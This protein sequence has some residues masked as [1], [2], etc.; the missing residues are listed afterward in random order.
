[1]L[2]SIQSLL[3]LDVDQILYNYRILVWGF[4]YLLLSIYVLISFLS[5]RNQKINYII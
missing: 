2:D 5:I 4:T 3:I 1:M